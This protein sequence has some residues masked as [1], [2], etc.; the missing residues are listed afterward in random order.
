M[1]DCLERMIASD[2]HVGIVSGSDINKLLEQFPKDLIPRLPWV[3][4]ENG[5]VA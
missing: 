1:T 4:T 3:F 5:L 2:V